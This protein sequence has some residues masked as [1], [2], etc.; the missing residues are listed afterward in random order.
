MYLEALYE[1]MY[2]TMPEAPMSRG[3]KSEY[4]L[5]VSRVVPII[6]WVMNCAIIEGVKIGQLLG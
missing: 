2:Q 3:F 1:G 4:L 6:S 5:V